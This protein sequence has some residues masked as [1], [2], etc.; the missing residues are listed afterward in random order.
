VTLRLT[1]CVT[2]FEL[3]LLLVILIVLLVVLC[4][5]NIHCDYYK[6][7]M[8]YAVITNGSCNSYS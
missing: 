1:I 6:I 8:T 4:F 7:I 3:L 5:D 2:Q